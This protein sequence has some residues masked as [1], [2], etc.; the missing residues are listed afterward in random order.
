MAKSKNTTK[1]D[2]NHRKETKEERKARLE[3]T[4]EARE[5]SEDSRLSIT[6]IYRYLPILHV[7]DIVLFSS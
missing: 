3:S 5:V 2:G 4:Q 7:A 1:K 6:K